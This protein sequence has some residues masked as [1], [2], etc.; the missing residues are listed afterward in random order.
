MP[1]FSTMR[2]TFLCKIRYLNIGA[3]NQ[4]SFLSKTVWLIISNIVKLNPKKDRSEGMIS[5]FQECMWKVINS[6]YIYWIYR[7]FSS[8]FKFKKLKEFFLCIRKWCCIVQEIQDCSI[9]VVHSALLICQWRELQK[10]VSLSK[11]GHLLMM[12]KHGV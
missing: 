11:N 5:R 3:K 7:L 10:V 8:P 2:A 9:V 6:Q 1:H 4:Q 12:A